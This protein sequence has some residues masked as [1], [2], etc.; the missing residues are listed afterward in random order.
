MIVV[1]GCPR[2]GTSLMMD[3]M[4]VVF[5][6]NKI[7]GTKFPQETR[8]KQRPQESDQ[9]YAIR[10]YGL[11]KKDLNQKDRIS[12]SK[13]LNPNGFWECQYT[14]Q[15]VRYSLAVEAS[16]STLEENGQKHICKIV[17]QGLANSDPKYINSI[18]YMLR[19]PKSVAKSQENLIR[20]TTMRDEW[21]KRFDLFEGK[22][23]HTPQ[24]FIRVT[25]A[26]AK[27]I[28]QNPDIP[29]IYVN[30]EDLLADPDSTLIGI[31]DFLG[32]GD[33]EKAVPIIDK[34][35]YRSHPE[36]IENELWEDAFF[37]YEKFK[38]KQ[39]TEIVE[40]MRDKKRATN[41]QASSWQC[42]RTGLR[43]VEAH[44]KACISDLRFRDS[45][46][47]HAIKSGIDWVNEPCAFECA[48][49]L[50]NVHISIE[51]SINNNSWL[52]PIVSQK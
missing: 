41:R 26:A 50:D 35:L 43:T 30:Y 3:C 52:G 37:V 46:K 15:G 11:E 27:W 16:M 5:G 48:H 9:E 23:V 28:I 31:G 40:Y 36:E 45:L 22:K 25:T 24:M 44:C 6:D 7:I 32:Y 8:L 12:K 4:R 39:F 19:N 20:N 51:E 14:V 13:D 10:L 17:S 29:I 2:S 47:A 21:G 49:D 18:I 34:K 33:F 38:N 1:S 42:Y